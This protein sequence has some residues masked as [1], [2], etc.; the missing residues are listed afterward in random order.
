MK[1][2]SKRE[3]AGFGGGGVEQTLVKPSLCV[4]DEI[5]YVNGRVNQWQR[6]KTGENNVN[7]DKNRRTKT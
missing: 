3:K 2:I 6:E 4:D 7:L 1:Y 5:V